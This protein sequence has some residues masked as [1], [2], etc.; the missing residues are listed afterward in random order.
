MSA[1]QGAHDV[2]AVLTADGH[3]SS[4]VCIF[5]VLTADGHVSSTVCIFIVLT[6]DGHV[7]STVCIFTV[8]T[9]V[10]QVSSAVCMFTVLTADGHVSSTV[11]IFTVLTDVRHVSST[12]CIFTVLTDVRHVSSTVCM[13]TVLTDV[14]HVSSTVCMFTVVTADEHVS[15]YI[16]VLERPHLLACVGFLF[17]TLACKRFCFFLYFYVWDRTAWISCN[18]SCYEHR[19]SCRRPPTVGAQL[20]GSRGYSETSGSQTFLWLKRQFDLTIEFG[21]GGEGGDRGVHC[22]GERSLQFKRLWKRRL[23]ALGLFCVKYW[24]QQEFMMTSDRSFTQFFSHPS[25]FW[26]IGVLYGVTSCEMPTLYN[27]PGPS[28]C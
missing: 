1:S 2:F 9:D 6:A 28:V 20:C 21:R 24:S 22:V 11:C 25:V 4:T 17:W 8:L 12:V 27:N 7:S 26:F 10:R 16:F 23:L 14:R 3:V 13:F 18:R 19:V 5:T 15:V